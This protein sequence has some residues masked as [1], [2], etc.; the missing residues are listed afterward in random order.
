MWK[1]IFT[2]FL[3]SFRL[4]LS[5]ITERKSTCWEV[6]QI[7]KAMSKIWGSLLKRGDRKLPIFVFLRRHR[8]QTETR[9]KQFKK[10]FKREGT[11]AQIR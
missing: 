5:E 4:P 8:H 6:S 11:F 9:D 10:I 2:R 1:S 7:R 3:S